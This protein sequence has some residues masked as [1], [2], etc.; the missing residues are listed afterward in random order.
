MPDAAK[1]DALVLELFDLDDLGKAL[2]AFDKRVLHGLAHRFGK[3]QELRWAQGLA[4]QENHF[5][6][7]PGCAQGGDALRRGRLQQ[8]NAGEGGA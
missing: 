3:A 6:C 4:G 2:Y 1:V 8:V 7:Q 5:V